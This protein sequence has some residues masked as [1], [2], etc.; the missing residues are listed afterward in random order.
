MAD[1]RLPPALEGREGLADF[2]HRLLRGYGID[3]DDIGRVADLKP[4]VR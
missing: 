2:G 1:D 3:H 4:I